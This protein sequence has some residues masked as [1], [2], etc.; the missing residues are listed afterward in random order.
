MDEI[1][2]YSYTLKS[3]KENG[4]RIH[5]VQLYTVARVPSESFITPLS[6][7]ELTSIAV[8]VKEIAGIPS[9]IYP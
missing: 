2:K 7:A 5:V 3:I 9:E 1:E 4:G 8:K 6:E